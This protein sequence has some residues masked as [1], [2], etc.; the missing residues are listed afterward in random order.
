[1]ENFQ[2]TGSVSN[3]HVGREFEE[4]AAAFFLNQGLRLI[5]NYAVPVGIKITSSVWF[6]FWLSFF[7]STY[8]WHPV[9]FSG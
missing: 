8:L 2:R 9:F 1:M 4:T 7:F 6:I 3:A 5:K